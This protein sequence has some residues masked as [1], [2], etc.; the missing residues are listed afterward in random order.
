M[1][2]QEVLCPQDAIIAVDV[3]N[4][5]CPGGALGI[6]GG[7]A[8]VPVLNDWLDKAA[9]Q[10]ALVVVSRD[11]HPVAHCSFEAQGGPWPEHCLQDTE[12]AAFHPE[13]RLPLG[14]VRVSKGTAFDRDAYSAFDG[15]GLQSFLESRGI[16]RVW[17]G[18]LACDVCVKATVLDACKFGFETHLIVAATRAVNPDQLV[19]V[20]DEMRGAGTIIEDDA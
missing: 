18:G 1:P 19:T 9:Q 13:L 17:I 2:K 3:Q 12:G 4:D 7:D 15:T 5:F 16:K 20:I 6:D 14:T 11:W 10:G 8:V